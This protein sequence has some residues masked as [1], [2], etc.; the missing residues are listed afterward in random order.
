MQ[1]N[2][3]IALPTEKSPVATCLSLSPARWARFR[4]LDPATP[5]ITSAAPR[6]GRR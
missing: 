5:D 6:I 2:Y 4:D 1:S 3:G